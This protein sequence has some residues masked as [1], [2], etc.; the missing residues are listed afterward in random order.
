[1]S[2]P[3]I[4]GQTRKQ[5]VPDHLEH[6][7]LA[8][9]S[10]VGHVLGAGQSDRIR[11]SVGRGKRAI[12]I[13]LSALNHELRNAPD[14]RTVALM[15]EHIEAGSLFDALRLAGSQQRFEGVARQL[16]IAER[17]R[18]E[19]MKQAMSQCGPRLEHR[20]W[21]R[22][23]W[24]DEALG[25]TWE[26]VFNKM[27]SWQQR[28]SFYRWVD[29][30][31]RNQVIEHHRRRARQEQRERQYE[32]ERELRGETL[33]VSGTRTT[34]RG[35]RLSLEAF[36]ESLDVEK[37]AIWDD[38]MALERQNLSREEIY[39]RIAAKRGLGAEA[40]KAKLVRLR[41]EYRELVGNRDDLSRVVALWIGSEQRNGQS[42]VLVSGITVDDYKKLFLVRRVPHVGFHAFE[43][44]F[45][46][47]SHW[48]LP[49]DRS[50]LAIVDNSAGLQ[51]ALDVHLS[52]RVVM[53]PCLFR[54]TSSIVA[55]LSAHHRDRYRRQLARAY[56]A[57]SPEK[58]RSAL[59]C[60]LARLQALSTRAAAL[61]DAEFDASLAFKRL[62]L[63]A[64]LEAEFSEVCFVARSPPPAESAAWLGWVF[65]LLRKRRSR[66]HRQ[67][68]LAQLAT[69]LG[70][71][72]YHP[73]QPS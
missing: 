16:R 46:T 50:T 6:D 69:T 47:I 39:E 73:A 43:R 19:V 20:A 40:V 65:A 55:H 8:R 23:G 52:D 66:A 3:V 10:R 48:G 15:S 28:G 2:N 57:A 24:H 31:Y 9:M 63:P 26:I 67:D 37:R 22:G 68:A 13:A 14:D 49:A 51:R 34:H 70:Q 32:A 35:N 56:R 41:R 38:A 29:A 42:A 71:P 5:A 61:L 53:Q 17:A 36:V 33:A 59:G 30:I 58:A 18:G 54:L 12:D 60:I 45:E 44:L 25:T 1:M 62:G 72:E 27:F 11:A 64:C 4:E 7:M 21:A